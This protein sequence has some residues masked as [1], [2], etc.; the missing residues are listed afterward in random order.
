[1]RVEPGTVIKTLQQ[2]P[3]GRSIIPEYVILNLF[4]DLFQAQ[5]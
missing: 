5:K 1:M 4:Q 3:D 2:K